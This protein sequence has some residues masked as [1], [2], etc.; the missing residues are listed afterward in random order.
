MKRNWIYFA[1]LIVLVVV[2]YFTLIKDRTGSYSKKDTAFAVEDTTA[3]SKIMLTNLKGD[4][5]LLENENG[6]WRLNKYYSPRP[7]ALHNLLKTM[8]QLEVKIPVSNS[9]HN[10]VIT[11]IATRRVHVEIYDKTGEKSK[12]FYIGDNSDALNGTFMLM[13]GSE[14]AFLVNIPG[15]TG[16]A[17]TVFFTDETDWKSKQIFSYK[18][19]NI[20]QIDLTYT[21]RKDSSFSIVR[22]ADNTFELVGNTQTDKPLNPEIVNYYL[23]QFNVLNAEYFILENDKRDSLLGTTPACLMSVTDKN[24]VTTILKIYY[25]PLTARSK[26]Q[27]TLE[28]KPIEFDLDKYYGVFNNDQDLGIIQ[29][30]VFGKLMVGPQFFYRQRPGNV[31]VLNQGIGVKK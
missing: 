5:I 11:N 18:P 16:F 12:G 28:D 26:M 7:D 31:N 9:M 22:K 6:I 25:R 19:E 13:E 14:H 23:K 27:F 4:S 8:R 10:T 17:A 30:F 20:N 29:N 1:I 2:A 3:I 15:F 24:N 21:S